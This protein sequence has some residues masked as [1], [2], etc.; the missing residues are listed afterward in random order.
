MAIAK[1]KP[2]MKKPWSGSKADEKADAKVMKGMTPAQKAAFE[3][4]DKEMDKNPMSRAEDTKKD[5]ALAAK[6]KKCSNGKCGKCA[7]CKG[8]KK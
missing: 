6:V 5:K 4:G 1:K 7:S 3:Q 2:K 8:T